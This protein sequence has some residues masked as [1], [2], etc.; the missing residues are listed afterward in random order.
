VDVPPALDGVLDDAAWQKAQASD[1]FT[2]SYP[3]DGAAPS[4]RTVVRIVYDDDSLY[5]SFD[6]WQAT[7]VVERLTRRDRIVESDWVAV[8]FGS[9]FDHKSTFFFGVYASGQVADAIR[10]DD[11]NMSMDWDENWEAKTRQND[12]GYAVEMRI[13]LRI[14]RFAT[15][16]EQSWDLQATRYVSELQETDKWAYWPRSMGGEVSHYGVLDGLVGLESRAPF[17]VRPFVVG[18]VRRRDAS[19]TQL[20]SGYDVTG[21]VGGDLKWHP[22]QDLTLDATLNPDFAQVEADQVVLNLT[23]FETYYP[24]RRPFF[25]EGIDTFNT[26]F[27]LLYT[28]RIGRVPS[29][30]TLRSD[31]AFNEHLVDVPE[32]ATIYD[33]T[34]LTGRIADRWTVGTLQAVTARNDVQIQLADG[35]RVSRLADPTTSFNLVRLRRDL[36]D[37]A[38][39]GIVATGTTRAE[40]TLAYPAETGGQLCPSGDVRAFGARCFNDEYVG[41]VDWRWRSRGGEWATGGQVIGSTLARGP[42]RSVPDGTVIHDGDVGLGTI[43]Y[44]NKEGGEHWVGGSRIDLE[45]RKLEINELGY[46]PRANQLAANANIEY[47]ELTPFGP[48]L[49]AHLN[50][51]YG[52]TYNTD[53]LFIGQG[54]YFSTWGRFKN[55]WGWYADTHYR[56]TKF[57][58]R[59]VGDG[60]ALE[61]E[62]RFGGELQV[63]SDSTKRVSFSVDQIA[64]A[65]Y[66]GAN[67]QGNAGVTVRALPQLDIDFLPQWLYTYG[68]PRFVQNGS[69]PGQY[70]FGRLAAANVGAVLRSTYTFFPRLTLQ[71]YAQLFLASGHYTD[72]S[73]YLSNPTG[74]RP[75]IRV[76][77]LTPYAGPPLGGNPDFE[78]GALNINV[79]LRWEYRLGSLLYLVYTRAQTPNVSLG[80]GDVGVLTLPAVGRAPAADAVLLKISYWWGG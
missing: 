32:P 9:R 18:R 56:G 57:D 23:T 12:H 74:K 4:N 37:N 70:V 29:V 51:S 22:T 66:D 41:G 14:L 34:K 76:A 63:N 16:A 10:F 59:E 5:V 46:N 75:N 20:A 73:Q 2:Q 48:F 6:C 1:R 65:I 79:V 68:E 7:P 69:V 8:D 40:P 26:P 17:E 44:L 27:Q 15:R 28:R 55:F 54:A 52:T 11:T 58:D 13:P 33:A 45:T 62:G 43:A 31:P 35:S 21:S 80:P 64:D 30:P 39:F 60:S 53:G 47:R 71:V 61:R 77:D 50:P 24:E 19:T 38:H 36:G 78:Q 3:H 67:F 72:L 42:D 25:L 49:E